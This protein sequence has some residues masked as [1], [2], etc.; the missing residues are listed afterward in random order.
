MEL[1]EIKTKVLGVFNKLGFVDEF[2]VDGT[3]TISELDLDSLDVVELTMDLEREF[4]LAISDPAM[5]GWKTIQDIID[6]VSKEIND[7]K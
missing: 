5:E 3:K 2:E 7:G 1:N 6:Y 4:N